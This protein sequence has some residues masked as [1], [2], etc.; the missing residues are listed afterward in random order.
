MASTGKRAQ[1][2]KD[3]D[4]GEPPSGDSQHVSSIHGISTSLLPSATS[5]S[6]TAG[7]VHRRSPGILINL[8]LAMTLFFALIQFFDPAIQEHESHIMLH[9][10]GY[11]N[12]MAIGLADFAGGKEALRR[13]NDDRTMTRES[14]SRGRERIFDLLNDAGVLPDL[15]LTE[16]NRLPMWK[17]VSE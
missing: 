1:K 13:G 14:L 6:T 8:G 4:L 17:T 16:I 15:S 12:P 10:Q 11:H 7:I 9:N 2:K 5:Q 3:D